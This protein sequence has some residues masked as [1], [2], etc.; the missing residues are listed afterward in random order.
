ME[1]RFPKDLYDLDEYSGTRIHGGYLRPR[2]PSAIFRTFLK[3]THPIVAP[4]TAVAAGRK[5]PP[6][7]PAPDTPRS[8]PIT[9]PA[10]LAR[11]SPMFR[12]MCASRGV[13]TS[14]KIEVFIQPHSDHIGNEISDF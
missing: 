10:P 13:K 14:L 5:K 3:K 2:G 8:R 9:T 1:C 11:A 6:W 12:T 7:I 4:V